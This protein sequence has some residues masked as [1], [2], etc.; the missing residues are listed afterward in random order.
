MSKSKKRKGRKKHSEL[1]L[2]KW[3][4]REIRRPDEK[5]LNA[6][7]GRP[8]NWD[9]MEDLFDLLIVFRDNLPDGEEF[10]MFIWEMDEESVTFKLLGDYGR[11]SWSHTHRGESTVQRNL[12][13]MC[14]YYIKA[15]E[16][17]FYRVRKSRDQQK[18][19]MRMRLLKAG[20]NP[21]KAKIQ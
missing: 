9:K 6:Y 5:L 8:G 13:F 15:M 12:L 10:K 3:K 11:K 19:E 4:E 2:E 1:L 7:L 16:N 18:E 21:D 14:E 20:Y 17:D